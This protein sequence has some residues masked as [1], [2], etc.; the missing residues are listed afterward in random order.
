MMNQEG[1]MM[2]GMGLVWLLIIIVF[3]LAA[4]TL[5]K[6]LFRGDQK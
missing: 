2:L 5:V 6:Y 3:L 1:M 4:A